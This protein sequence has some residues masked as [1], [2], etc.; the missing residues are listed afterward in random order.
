[1]SSFATY[2]LTFASM[3]VKVDK[4]IPFEL[5]GPLACGVT[6]GAGAVFNAAK[7]NPGDSIVVYG[8]GSVGLAAIMAATNT[9]ANEIIAVDLHDSRLEIAKKRGATHVINFE[10]VNASEE[11]QRNPGL[12]ADF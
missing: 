3:V 9:P 6:T 10:F 1:Q 2:S 4:D 5:L 11:I 12:P 7:P 8:T